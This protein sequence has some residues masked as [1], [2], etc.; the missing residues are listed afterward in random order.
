MMEKDFHIDKVE[1][2]E[3]AYEIFLDISGI[4]KKGRKYDRMKEDAFKMRRTLEE[5]IILKTSGRWFKDVTLNGEK[6]R[7][8]SQE[9]V[10]NAFQQIEPE[11]V[12][13]AFVYVVSAGDFVFSNEPIMNQ[14]YADL[15]GTAFTDAMRILLKKEFEKEARLSDSFGPGFYGMDVS[16]MKKISV[17]LDFDTLNLELKNDAF[18]LPLKSCAGIFF[19]IT[20]DYRYLNSFCENCAAAN[21]SCV[22]CQQD[23]RSEYV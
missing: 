7:I 2:N 3:L 4:H 6:A 23:K 12:K 9:F 16:E 20:E 11:T 5:R 14:L 8:G 17:L 22:L 19:D 21:V 15:W 10:C 1:C 18:I 13:G